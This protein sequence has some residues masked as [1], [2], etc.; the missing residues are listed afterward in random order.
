MFSFFKKSR[1]AGK[2]NMYLRRLQDWVAENDGLTPTLMYKFYDDEKLCEVPESIIAVGEFELHSNERAG[3][4][5]EI[6]NDSIV[7]GRLFFPSGLVSW[8][9]SLSM[10][11]KMAG[12]SLFT[13]L[14]RAEENHRQR[15]PQ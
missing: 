11:A 15:F 5:V 9:K 1:M 3:F 12:V 7:L 13:A 6:L 14:C 10:Q 2:E 4:Y 8:H